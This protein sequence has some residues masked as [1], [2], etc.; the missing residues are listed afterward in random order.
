MIVFRF[1]YLLVK[2]PIATSIYAKG[3]SIDSLYDM[4][5]LERLGAEGL[6]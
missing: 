2:W 6:L 5:I 3:T 4:R 1:P